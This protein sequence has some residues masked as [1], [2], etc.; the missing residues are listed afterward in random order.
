MVKFRVLVSGLFSCRFA[1]F[2]PE[3]S[4]PLRKVRKA[5]YNGFLNLVSVSSTKCGTGGRI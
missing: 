2:A 4:C 5:P 1:S 3:E